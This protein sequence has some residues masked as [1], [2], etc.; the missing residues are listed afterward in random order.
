MW[1]GTAWL[2]CLGLVFK[3]SYCLCFYWSNQNISI[4][5]HFKDVWSESKSPIH[6]KQW[7]FAV[8]WLP[9]LY[10]TAGMWLVTMVIVFPIHICLHNPTWQLSPWT[11]LSCKTEDHHV[12]HLFYLCITKHYH[13]NQDYI[14]VSTNGVIMINFINLQKR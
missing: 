12:S 1:L 13:S 14:N 5:L 8:R 2:D 4:W 11:A 9:A 6:S 10:M 7:D 3:I